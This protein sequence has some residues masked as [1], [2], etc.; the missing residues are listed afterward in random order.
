MEGATAEQVC[1]L[2]SSD[3]PSWD[4]NALNQILTPLDAAAVRQ[5]PLGRSLQDIWAWSGE[6]HGLYTVKYG[7]RPLASAAAQHRSYV[8]SR[9]AHSNHLNGPLSQKLWKCKVP[10]MS[11]F[12]GGASSTSTYQAGPTFIDDTLTRLFVIHVG[13]MMKQP[14]MLFWNAHM[15]GS[16]GVSFESLRVSNSLS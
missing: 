3:G 12:S 6:R 1:D 2:L 15:R 9:A 5:S 13:L 4:E 14:S 16:S 10:Q 8:Q 7:Y 11:E